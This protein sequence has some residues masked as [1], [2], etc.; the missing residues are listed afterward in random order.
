MNSTVVVGFLV[1]VA[2]VAGIYVLFVLPGE[3][4]YHETKLRLMQER[5]A[6]HEARQAESAETDGQLRGSESD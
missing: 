1:A 6:R 4:K 2:V 3:R 5:I